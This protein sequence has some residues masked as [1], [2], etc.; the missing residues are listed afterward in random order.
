MT[1]IIIVDGMMAFN[2]DAMFRFVRAEGFPA[3]RAYRDRMQA[4]PGY[5]RALARAGGD[6]IY[7]QDF[8]ELPDV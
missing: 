2:I 4:R 1:G 3:I 7:A 6:T 8:Y 5:Q